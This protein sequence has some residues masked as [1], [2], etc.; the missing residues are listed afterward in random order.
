MQ[1]EFLACLGQNIRT[2]R[3]KHKWSQEKLAEQSALHR[4]YI[5]GLERGERNIS[6]L[7]A[8]KVAQALGVPVALLFEGL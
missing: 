1:E 3:E 5:G 4:T 2:I 8:A 7:A 6:V